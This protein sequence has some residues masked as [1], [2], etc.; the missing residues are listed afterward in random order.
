MSIMKVRTLRGIYVSRISDDMNRRF[1]SSKKPNHEA[2]RKESEE[3]IADIKEKRA[4]KN[5]ETYN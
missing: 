5:N 2:L 4:M 3:F 1:L